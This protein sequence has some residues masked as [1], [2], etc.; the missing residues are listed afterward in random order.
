M[1][2]KSAPKKPIKSLKKENLTKVKK[3]K[4]IAKKKVNKRIKK[5][6]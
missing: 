6:K 3:R 4:I 1:V 2:K 5:L